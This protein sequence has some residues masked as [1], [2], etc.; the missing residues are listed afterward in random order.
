MLS[1][2]VEGMLSHPWQL[3]IHSVHQNFLRY[4]RCSRRIAQ[5][6]KWAIPYYIPVGKGASRW[7]K[8]AGIAI[9]EEHFRK[10]GARVFLSKQGKVLSSP[11]WVSRWLPH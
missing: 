1:K 4:L 9:D 7:M 8:A 3:K 2:F 10:F 11:K 6:Q 5:A